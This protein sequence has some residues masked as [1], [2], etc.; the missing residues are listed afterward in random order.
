MYHKWSCQAD[1]LREM[2]G[3]DLSVSKAMPGRSVRVDGDAQRT[4]EAHSGCVCDSFSR[5]N[6][7]IRELFGKRHFLNGRSAI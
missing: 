4:G 2:S 1:F 7:Q 6:R 5:D 3:L